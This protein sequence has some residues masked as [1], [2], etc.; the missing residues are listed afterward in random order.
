MPQQSLFSGQDKVAK[1][2]VVLKL[3]KGSLSQEQIDAIRSMVAGSVEGLT[4]ENVTLVDAD[5]RV[6]MLAKHRGSAAQADVEQALETKL[7]AMLEPLAGHDNVHA[8]VNVS[9][10]ETSRSVTD[11]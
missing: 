5:G 7:I 8:T 4:G 1:A 3:R 11:S 10:D 9:Y 6:N 2:S